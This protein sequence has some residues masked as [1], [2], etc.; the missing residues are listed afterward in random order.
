MKTIFDVGK[1]LK[2]VRVEYDIGETVRELVQARNQHQ[3]TNL[4]PTA[5]TVRDVL[6]TWLDGGIS[7][8]E[9]RVIDGMLQIYPGALS[10]GDRP[11]V[12]VVHVRHSAFARFRDTFAHTHGS[13]FQSWIM[14]GRLQNIQYQEHTYKIL[15][16]DP[17]VLRYT[18]EVGT[19]PVGASGV[20]MF[21]HQVAAQTYG[22][23]EH[24]YQPFQDIH[25]VVADDGTVTAVAWDQ[26]D[27]HAAAHG[28]YQSCPFTPDSE[29]P[30][31]PV[32]ARRV[33]EEILAAWSAPPP[34]TTISQEE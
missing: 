25:R 20:N 23:G 14:R 7:L 22:P 29:E 11:A 18:R 19:V 3:R 26:S 30:V 24:Y 32:V 4:V 1:N 34:I 13:N 15:T 5:E 17:G 33:V 27:V 31:P 6:E 21:L 10:R 16:E 12:L 9:W 8:S 2:T 28:Y